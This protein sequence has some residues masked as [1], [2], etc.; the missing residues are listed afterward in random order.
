MNATSAGRRLV[1]HALLNCIHVR[2][3]RIG[4]TGQPDILPAISE[5]GKAF[6]RNPRRL[7]LAIRTGMA[8]ATMDHIP[9]MQACPA[10]QN[11]IPDKWVE[12]TGGPILVDLVEQL[13]GELRFQR[14]QRR[15]QTIGGRTSALCWCG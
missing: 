4:R 2:P 12:S 13:L 11:R 3:G 15:R 6:V 9:T 1:D 10:G 7:T 5:T 8:E 14:C